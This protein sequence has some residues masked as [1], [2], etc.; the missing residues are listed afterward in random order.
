MSNNDAEAAEPAPIVFDA[1]SDL[2]DSAISA[3]AALLIDVAEQD[4]Q[5]AARSTAAT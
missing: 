2:S 1:D 4:Q 3:L 5:V